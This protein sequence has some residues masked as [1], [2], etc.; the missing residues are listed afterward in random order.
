LIEKAPRVM[1]ESLLFPYQQ[2]MEFASQLY[3]HGGWK[4]ISTAYTELPKSTEQVLH[5]EKYLEREAPVK[6]ELPDVAPALG[7]NWKRVDYDVNGEWGYYLILDEFLKDKAAS[8]RASAGWG[9][10]RY[11][12]YTEPKTGAVCILQRSEWDTP[13]D[14]TEFYDAYV[15]RT[16]LRYPGATSIITPYTSFSSKWADGR[17][18]QTNEG[19]V[20]I[21]RSDKRVMIIEGLPESADLKKAADILLSK[22]FI[23]VVTKG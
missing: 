16:E 1:R 17:A 23:R 2:G 19:K 3:K 13:G 5:T 10:D 15:K 4:Q 22:D 20:L 11:A 14:A 12:V 9:G 8:R 6:V 21:L 7:A 18:W